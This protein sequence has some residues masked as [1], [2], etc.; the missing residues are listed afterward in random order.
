[1][2]RSSLT[3]RGKILLLA[4][5]VC[6]SLVVS[7]G[8][9]WL[10]APVPDPF[11]RSLVH[12]RHDAANRYISSS[13]R[14]NQTVTFETDGKVL[15]GISGATR[16]T[17]NSFGF[18]SASQHS[19]QKPSDTLRVFCVGGSTTICLYL[20]DRDAWPAVVERQLQAVAPENLRIEVVNA[21]KMGDSTRDHLDM[22]GERIVMFDP[23]IIVV[24]AGINDMWLGFGPHY[25]PIKDDPGSLFRGDSESYYDHVKACLTASQLVR[26]AVYLRRSLGGQIVGGNLELDLTGAWITNRRLNWRRAPYI[27]ELPSG[28]A[29]KEFSTNLR[30]IVGI[31]RAHG[32]TCALVTQSTLFRENLGPDEHAL[33]WWIVTDKEDK[34][35][36]LPLSFLT[37]EMERYNNVIRQVASDFDLPLY[38]AAREIPPDRRHFYDEC[39]LNVEGA[40]A[41]ATGVTET[42]RREVFPES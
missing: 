4:L 22:I 41:L 31:C 27:N 34:E 17:I 26:R 5:C 29:I 40:R 35:H 39:H 21:G 8:I 36:R 33:F 9:L 16:F 2:T 3:L 19:L 25:S 14:P 1:M 18:R 7:E 10:A 37:A 28:R 24:C 6:A 38:D 20:D 32:I 30:S 42:L 11:D 12:H 13:F 15:P 23:D